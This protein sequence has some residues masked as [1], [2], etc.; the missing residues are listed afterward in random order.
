MTHV[1][2]SARIRRRAT[3]AADIPSLVKR[4]RTVRS[5]TQEQLAREMGVTF[6]TVNAWEKGR[7]RPIPALVRRLLDMAVEVGVTSAREAQLIAREP[8]SSG[9]R[10]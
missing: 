8:K 7:H 3:S 5:L 2:P 4:L 1:G 6:S 10:R 9:R